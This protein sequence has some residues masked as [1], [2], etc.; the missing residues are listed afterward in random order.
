MA[1]AD[2]ATWARVFAAIGTFIV[3]FVAAFSPWIHRKLFG[4]RA[5]I[6]RTNVLKTPVMAIPSGAFVGHS[7]YLWLILRN[8][9]GSATRDVQVWVQRMEQQGSGND[10]KPV[11]EWAGPMLLIWSPGGQGSL[12]VFHRGTESVCN[13]GHFPDPGQCA[14]DLEKGLVLPAPGIGPGQTFFHLDIASHPLTNPQYFAPGTYRFHLVVAGHDLPPVEKTVDLWFDGTW[15]DDPE[16]FRSQ[17]LK[18]S[19]R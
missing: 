2:L 9:G 1:S 5:K 11:K 19:V 14:A 17:H 7:H 15:H 13:L 4:P 18:F 8:K 16:A 10:F 3:A 12:P 6:V